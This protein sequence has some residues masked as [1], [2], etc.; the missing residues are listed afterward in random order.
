V[1]GFICTFTRVKRREIDIKK[2]KAS[3]MII[4]SA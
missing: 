2:L 1:R 3:I 4:T